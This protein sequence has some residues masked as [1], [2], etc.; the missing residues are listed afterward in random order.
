MSN[1]DTG[2]IVPMGMAVTDMAATIMVVGAGMCFIS[3]RLLAR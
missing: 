3:M 1:R 2:M